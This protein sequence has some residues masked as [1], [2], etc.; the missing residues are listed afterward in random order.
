[1]RKDIPEHH[2]GCALSKIVSIGD[3]DMVVELLDRGA[4][5]ETISNEDGFYAYPALISALKAK[6]PSLVDLF[7]H[8]GAN[9]NAV[10]SDSPILLAVKWGDRSVIEK[11]LVAGATLSSPGGENAFLEAVKRRDLDLMERLLYAGA[12]MKGALE[13]AT[14]DTTVDVCN[15]LLSHGA[16]PHDSRALYNAYRLK[17]PSFG[18]LLQAHKARYPFGIGGFG[19]SV[20]WSALR[21]NDQST[22][23][24]LLKHG[25]DPNGFVSLNGQAGKSV[26]PFFFT[27]AYGARSSTSL[28]ELFL[29][30]GH[31]SRAFKCTPQSIVSELEGSS[32][33]RPGPMITALL[34]AVSTKS[35]SV[36]QLLSQHEDAVI[37]FPASGR[38]KRTPLQRAAEVGDLDLVKFFYG[39]GANVNAPPAR[40]GGATALQLAAKGGY[41]AIVLYL[42]SKGA[43]VDAPRAHIDGMTALES[44]AA[45]GR[46]D[47]L[48][49]LLRRGAGSGGTDLV[50]FQRAFA[51]AE[52]E[53]HFPIV[54]MLQTHLQSIGQNN[55]LLKHGNPQIRRTEAVAIQHDFADF[56]HLVGLEAQERR[57]KHNMSHSNTFTISGRPM[58]GSW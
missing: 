19:S 12:S 30:H 6:N 24:L 20:L 53:S 47:T 1:M 27:I 15:W 5:I 42:L 16:D 9:P 49:V 38:I 23:E 44:A 2:L 46:V 32:D 14:R 43:Q 25:A 11:L 22:V 7:L 56:H 33:G 3:Y 21:S 8:S 55:L 40:I 37:D 48:S 39:S 41:T 4:E 34:A 29:N 45:E 54:R 58:R 36:V 28:V 50:Q 17:T 10:E 26:T 18:A 57:Q 13:M 52:R 51:F 31:K 35:M